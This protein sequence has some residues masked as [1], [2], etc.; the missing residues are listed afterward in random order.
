MRK[1]LL[2]LLS[3]VMTFA[4]YGKTNAAVE[5]YA[6]TW[7]EPENGSI[8]L[9]VFSSS[10]LPSGTTVNEDSQVFIEA[11][12]ASGYYTK[13]LTANGV[14][15]ML[16]RTVIVTE[17]VVVE[18]TFEKIPEGNYI[19]RYPFAYHTHIDVTYNDTPVASGSILPANSN[20]TINV[21]PPTGVRIKSVT[22]N[23][24][25]IN[26]QSAYTVTS[27]LNIAYQLDIDNNGVMVY[28]DT[29]NEGGTIT[30]WKYVDGKVTETLNSGDTNNKVY[31]T[32][33]VWVFAIP[34]S[35]YILDKIEINGETQEIVDLSLINP[36]LGKQTYKGA[37]YPVRYEDI[38]I[39]ATFKLDSGIADAEETAA[40]RYDYASQTLMAGED[41][42]VY[43]ATGAVVM[44][45]AAGD[46]AS[47]ENLNNGVYIVKG[48]K[49][50][51]KIV[52]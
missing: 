45:V 50:L 33:E 43:N 51:L 42:T 2:L 21:V 13:S 22:A 4:F 23:G 41:V 12:P 40:N 34:E 6:I 30:A 7:D 26:N 35:G 18:A 5:A 27:D 29:Y 28:Y 47:F 46:E 48:S 25:E 3:L 14:D 31:V 39:T 15:I 1:S 32:Q 49:S 38:N 11:V 44:K 36:F 24:I 37:R 10:N 8:S 17:D 9:T 16:D 19:V 20:I 52:R